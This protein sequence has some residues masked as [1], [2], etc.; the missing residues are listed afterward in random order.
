MYLK[1]TIFIGYT[2]WSCSVFTICAI[3]NVISH[4]K[5][6]LYLLLLLSI[7]QAIYNYTSETEHV[8]RVY[9]VAAI[10]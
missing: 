4:V 3:H 1:Q 8:S 2:I 10:M 5:Y 6:V 7:M 9:N